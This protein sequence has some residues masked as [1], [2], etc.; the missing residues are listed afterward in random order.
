MQ[1]VIGGSRELNSMERKFIIDLKRLKLWL[2]IATAVF[3]QRENSLK[4]KLVK[5][6][7]ITSSQKCFDDSHTPVLCL[8]ATLFINILN[9]AV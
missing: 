3:Q 8:S 4:K 7:E 6:I 5:N 9:T 2:I 1:K